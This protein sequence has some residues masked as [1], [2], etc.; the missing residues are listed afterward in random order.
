[1]ANNG[2]F[3]DT[4]IVT[5]E[6]SNLCNY[7]RLHSKCPAHEVRGP[8]ILPSAAVADVI[9]TMAGQYYGVG[10][11]LAFHVY[12]EPLLDPRLFKFVEYA[13]SRLPRINIIL[14]SNGWYLYEVIAEELARAGVTHF[15][16]SAYSDA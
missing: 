10:K 14:W 9:D 7:S 2:W 6:L 4:H 11:F 8:E 13:R 16:V 1:M 5:L 3:H 15:M 12:N